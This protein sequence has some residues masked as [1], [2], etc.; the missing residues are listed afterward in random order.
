MIDA[1]ALP[2]SDTLD[3]AALSG[4]GARVYTSL[5]S[6]ER[7]VEEHH[8]EAYE[9]F[10]GLAAPLGR[11]L[12]FSPFLGRLLQQVGRQSP[13]NFR[14]LLG[15]KPLPSTKGRGYM[16]AGYL[17]LY[18][19]TGDREYSRKAV[20]C[21]EWLMEHKS[22]K[23]REYSWANHFDYSSRGGTYGKDDSIIVWTALV[24]QA[25]LDGFETLGDKRYLEVAD[26][27]CRWICG[28]PREHTPSGI[29]LSYHMLNQASVH[30]ASM[31]GAAML[32]RTWRH[33][34]NPEYLHLATAAMEYSCTRMLPDGSWLYGEEPRYH[35]V[36]NFHTGYNLDSLKCYI[37]NTGDRTWEPE[38]YHAFAYF[39]STFFE[40]NGRPKYYHDRTYP[41]DI[42]CSSQAVETLA[43]FAD[44]GPDVLPLAERV[45]NWTIDQMQDP[46]GYFYYRRYPLLVARIPM[47]HWGQATMFHAL[48][49]LLTREVQRQ[50]GR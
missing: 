16:A 33:R 43:K 18:K 29:C 15:V 6:V 35:W 9:P 38:L 27:V 7:W 37:D 47:M 30:N 22:S 1:P 13:F 5:K 20:S 40:A 42:Q 2:S 4:A 26:S 32:A 34:K 19:L 10:D 3:L 48:A 36:D 24:G 41:I 11:F 8:Y 50:S 31:L 46:S 39:T 21:L 12:R 23:F 28:L 25:F 44:V 49:L 45:A 14:P 17:T